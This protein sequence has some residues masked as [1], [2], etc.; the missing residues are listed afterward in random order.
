MRH[1]GLVGA[2]LMA[3]GLQGCA[4]P[5]IVTI[6]SYSADI[7]SYAATGKTVT[8][9]AYSAV[10]RSDCSFMR[11]FKEKPICTDY[12][13]DK[14]NV[15]AEASPSP[16]PSAAGTPAQAPAVPE[17]PRNRYVALGSFRDSANAE[18]SLARYAAYHPVMVAV[19]VHGEQFHRVTAGPLTDAEAARLK[20]KMVAATPARHAARG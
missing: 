9:H 20:E 17:P 8:D 19:V 13:S 18:R 14:K 7:V 10:A 4:L 3:L 5:P 6:A 11:V 15:V 16:A 2:F 12:P 1:A